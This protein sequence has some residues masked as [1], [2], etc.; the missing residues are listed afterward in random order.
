MLSRHPAKM[1]ADLGPRE[2]WGYHF[3]PFVRLDPVNVSR[4]SRIFCRSLVPS[5][6]PVCVIARLVLPA[7]SLRRR[8]PPCLPSRPR[9][10]RTW[11]ET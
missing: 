8:V 7:L 5:C 11:P 1:S 9:E 3:T 6:S 4:L 10:I 2:P